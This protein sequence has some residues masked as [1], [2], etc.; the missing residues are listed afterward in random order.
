MGQQLE[1]TGVW[2][3]HPKYGQQFKVTSYS[4]VL[5]AT[6]DGIR[7]YLRSGVIKGIGK[8]MA[9]RLVKHFGDQTLNIIEKHTENS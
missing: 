1:I 4:V 2:D 7:G 5:P 9:N 3:T 8:K 6:V